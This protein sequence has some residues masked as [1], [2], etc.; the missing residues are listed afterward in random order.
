VT[1]TS[2]RGRSCFPP[3]IQAA[4]H[5]ARLALGVDEID[6]LAPVGSE[7]VAADETAVRLAHRGGVATVVVRERESEPTPRLTCAATIAT[8][9]RVWELAGLTV[10]DG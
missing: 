1:L 5:F 2:L 3:S 4:Q 6:A 8:W 7:Q 9:M 10:E